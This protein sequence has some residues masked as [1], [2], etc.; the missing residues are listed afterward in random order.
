MAFRRQSQ[1]T[2][3]VRALPQGHLRPEL[4]LVLTDL[5]FRERQPD[6]ERIQLEG[7]GDVVISAGVDDLL[8]IVGLSAAGEDED[9]GALSV[10]GAS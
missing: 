8:E 7:F 2:M 1:L 10:R 6:F 3:P 5:T 4:Q 9:D